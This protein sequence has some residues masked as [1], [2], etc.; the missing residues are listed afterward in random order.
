MT[1]EE[2]LSNQ[3]EKLKLEAAKQEQNAAALRAAR[4]AAQQEGRDALARTETAAEEQRRALQLQLEQV[5][6]LQERNFGSSACNCCQCI[7]NI[8]AWT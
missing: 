5:C 4:D 6:V 2:S 8:M 7:A 3:I 1:A